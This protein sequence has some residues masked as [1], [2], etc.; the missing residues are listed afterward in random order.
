M[1]QEFLRTFRSFD[2]EEVKSHLLLMGDLSADC[3]ACQ[4]LG[5]DGYT[6]AECPAC[7][8]VFK[9]ATSRRLENNPGER[10]QFAKRMTEKRPDLT[11]IDYTDY[12][13]VLGKKKARDFFG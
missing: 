3:G 4:E 11:L 2:I 8:A 7:G 12:S 13:K 9:Y 5:I 10:F 6:A 1:A